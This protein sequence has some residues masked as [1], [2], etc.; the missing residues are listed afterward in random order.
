M[1]KMKPLGDVR[2]QFFELRN[3]IGES[4]TNARAVCRVQL[5]SAKDRP[6]WLG[7]R[8][9]DE[10]EIRRTHEFFDADLLPHALD[11]ERLRRFPEPM[12]RHLARG[13]AEAERQRLLLPTLRPW[14]MLPAGMRLKDVG[15]YPWSI[16][17]GEG[18]FFESPPRFE[19]N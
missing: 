15:R 19:A 17:D 4:E 8:T 11:E 2:V 7:I 6:D 18:N 1:A 10:L 13:A 12:R 16:Y 9:R 5:V 3:V 14:K